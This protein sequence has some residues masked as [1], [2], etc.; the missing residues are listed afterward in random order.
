M[1]VSFGII[2]LVDGRGRLP[3][4]DL[5]VNTGDDGRWKQ[6]INFMSYHQNVHI[7]QWNSYSFFVSKAVL[8]SHSFSN[9]GMP[10]SQRPAVLFPFPHMARGQVFWQFFISKLIFETLGYR[11]IEV[12]KENVCIYT[13]RFMCIQHATMSLNWGKPHTATTALTTSAVAKVG[14]SGVSNSWTIFSISLSLSV[15]LWQLATD[16]YNMVCIHQLTV[17][18]NV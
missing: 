15:Y 3:P 7:E 8:C 1:S 17:M 12:T 2:S 14:D 6:P 13:Y 5:E 18:I 11:N 9:I 4:L 10:S 16:E